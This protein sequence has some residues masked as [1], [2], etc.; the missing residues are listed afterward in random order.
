MRLIRA[1][2][3]CKQR[4][5]TVSKEAPPVSKKGPPPPKKIRS[6]A[7]PTDLSPPHPVPSSDKSPPGIFRTNCPKHKSKNYPKRPSRLLVC[8]IWLPS[9]PSPARWWQWRSSGAGKGFIKRLRCPSA[10]YY[11]EHLVTTQPEAVRCSVA[12]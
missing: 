6:G 12:P 5:L 10:P 11:D 3:D 8:G 2:R 9:P 4:S 7:P 1:L